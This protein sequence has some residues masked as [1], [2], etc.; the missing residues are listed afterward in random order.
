MDREDARVWQAVL[1]GEERADGAL[2]RPKDAPTV[3][4]MMMK[5]AVV[6]LAVG[7]LVL[8]TA[9][10]GASGESKVQEPEV[11]E[12]SSSGTLAD[13]GDK[14]T[15]SGAS[16]RWSSVEECIETIRAEFPTDP[17]LEMLSYQA[18]RASA[19]Y[20]SRWAL[21]A[22][23]EIDVVLQQYPEDTRRVIERAILCDTIAHLETASVVTSTELLVI[24]CI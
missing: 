3:G 19:G 11:V 5:W 24:R 14:P 10:A 9:C 1:C 7:A 15:S 13:V 4:G 6:G 21:E 23:C 17:E 16:A 12:D 22:A 2:G 8:A 18:K 20:Y